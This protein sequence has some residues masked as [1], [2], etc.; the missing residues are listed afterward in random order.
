MCQ[1]IK[2]A[3]I[4]KSIGEINDREMAGNFSPIIYLEKHSTLLN[5][6]A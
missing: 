1:K 4:K 6:Y 3:Q 2:A 5:S